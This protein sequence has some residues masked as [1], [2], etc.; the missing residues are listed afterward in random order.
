ME[1]Q[2]SQIRTYSKRFASEEYKGE[3]DRPSRLFREGE[4]C[5]RESHLEHGAL[6]V[7]CANF[8]RTLHAAILNAR[9]S[10]FI[11]GWDID[12][13][14]RLLRGDEEK[15]SEAPSVS[16]DLLKWKARQNPEIKIFLLRWDSS[17]TFWGNR[18]FNAQKVW[19]ED[20]PENIHVWLDSTIPVG[21][22]HHQKIVVIDDE[23]AFTGGMDIATGRWDER[24]HS[25]HE[26]ERYDVTGSYGPYHDIQILTHGKVVKDLAEIVRWRWKQAA[27]YDAPPF[28]GEKYLGKDLPEAWPK[29]IKP[30]FRN[31]NC[32]IARTIPWMGKVEPVKEVLEMYLDL[33]RRAESFLYIENQF[34]TSEIIADAINK[35]LKECPA[36][37]VLMIGPYNPQGLFESEGLWAPRIDFKKRV[38]EGVGASRVRMVY[39]MTKDEEG[40]RYYKRIH[41]KLFCV[42]D[43]FLTIG[44]SN[45][46]HRSMSLDTECDLVLEA[47]TEDHR[48][49]IRHVRN[50]LL[51]EHTSRSEAQIARMFNNGSDLDDIL[52]MPHPLTYTL[53]EMNDSNF[54]DQKFQSWFSSMADPEEPLFSTFNDK[55]RPMRNPKKDVLIGSLIALLVIAAGASF[56]ATHAEWVSPERISTFLED[57]RG[58]VWAFPLVCLI[59]VVGGLIMFPVTVLSL[60]TTAVFGALWGPIYAMIGALLSGAVL[61][62]LGNLFGMKSLRKYLGERIRNVVRRIEDT[63]VSGVVV[64]RLTP[65]APY[66]LVNLAAGIVSLRFFDF[67]AG[68]FLGLLP[69]LV[70]KGFL[71]DSLMQVLL[72][73]S[74]KN[75]AY[76]TGGIVLWLILV[77][78]SQKIVK[79]L[80]RSK[81][82]KSVRTAEGSA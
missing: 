36:L 59:Y 39:A 63:G 55:D 42:D 80:T 71:G 27:G 18:E 66:S 17:I 54:T 25:P 69:G 68:T 2:G 13:R 41:S 4:N 32:A 23:I 28:E 43:K 1:L 8:Y 15:N 9:K 12:S 22:S 10:I 62:W 77:F 64:I 53:Q 76:V 56:L 75:F 40:R 26:P 33:I 72:N 73:P 19:E 50:N 81:K 46:N 74:S 57:A 38:C 37:R 5:W 20:A 21:G 29:S 65:I 51:A 49:Q 44:S 35:R 61:Y 31:F 58:T 48:R 11:I 67:M 16:G 78:A 79:H 82:T 34:F 24:R 6:L 70:A 47:T 45:L 30:W 3:G 14:I 7:G 52:G 60:A